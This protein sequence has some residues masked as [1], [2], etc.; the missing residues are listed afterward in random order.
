M[1]AKAI[2][3]NADLPIN[4]WPEIIAATDYLINKIPMKKHEW[5]I[6]YQ[7]IIKHSSNL[8]HL[9]SFDCKTYSLNK[10]I[11]KKHKLQ[12]KAHVDH[13]I[14]YEARNIF[15]IWIFSQRKIIK[16]KDIIFDDQIS[17]NAEN[18]DLMQLIRKLMLKT[19]YE[20]LN[21]KTIIQITDIASD[22][23]EDVEINVIFDAD[24]FQ[25]SVESSDK[26]FDQSFDRIKGILFTSS[27]ISFSTFFS[28][29]HTPISFESVSQV[30]NLNSVNQASSAPIKPT[31]KKTSRDINAK[32]DEKNILSEKMKKQKTQAIRK[33]AYSTILIRTKDENV[34]AFHTIFSIYRTATFS[35][36]EFDSKQAF[37]LLNDIHVLIIRFI[38]FSIIFIQ[39]AIF[40][41]INQRMHRN[42]FFSKPKNY[43]QMLKD[44]LSFSFRAVM[45]TKIETL[46]IKNTWKKVSQTN[47]MQSI[48]NAI[49]IM[50]VFKY[51]FDEE[52]YV[53]KFKT[54]FVTRDDM[55]RINQ[56]T[57]AATLTAR[58]FRF[59]M[60]LMIAFN[61]NIRQ[62]DAINAFVN[63][64]IDESISCRTPQDWLDMSETLLILQKILYDLKQFSV[65]WH[66]HLFNTLKKLKFDFVSKMKCLFMSLNIH[67][68]LFFFV[69]DIV[70]IYETRH[71][72][73]MN[74]FQFRLF[75]KYEMRQLKEL[76]WFL[77]INV[78]KNKVTNKLKLNQ[79]S[80]VDKLII[81]FNLNHT[82]KTP[83]IF[84]SY[85]VLQKHQGQVSFQEIHV[86]QQRVDFINFAT[87][88][89]RIDVVFATFK[90]SKF[91]INSSAF[92]MKCVNRI[93][94][95]LTAKKLSIE[96]SLDLNAIN[97]M[98]V[99]NS[100]ALFAD[101][102]DTRHN[103]QKYAFKLFNELIDWKISKQKTIIINSTEA[104]L[105]AL[106]ATAKEYIW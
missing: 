102:F 69:D 106:S 2:R 22:S 49:F 3:I 64:F 48:S 30:F 1:K 28:F 46:K 87:I 77:K 72:N 21:M 50:W 73:E 84:L 56:N 13:L 16:I 90:L 51:K 52:E 36:H 101:D 65:L 8:D 100:N 92:H 96:F 105:L 67:I 35:I 54:R 20:S 12:K 85:E 94:R 19:M 40:N 91:F 43:N 4:L 58:I 80:Y 17:Y 5:K 79:D 9:H 63:S 6:S 38:D 86:Y 66:R 88:I 78:I 25:F 57:Y 7:L 27:P 32:F 45:I 31:N 24:D 47:V 103:S 98:F 68:L 41:L 42:T 61:L 37:E 75:E 60:I 76:Q 53:M 59:F 70:L 23:N 34:N 39:R 11:P 93:I 10:R 97:Q 99:V 29:S 82:A 62:Y 44:F 71:T 95:Y 55:Q 18:I 74:R 33:Q 89:I 15:R 26:S 14:D 104:E 83:Q 81:K